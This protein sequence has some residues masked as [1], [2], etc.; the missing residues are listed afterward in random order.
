MAALLSAHPPVPGDDLWLTQT[1]E[2]AETVD[3]TRVATL[4]LRMRA[5]LSWWC[6]PGDA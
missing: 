5:R 2:H 4:G 6:R 3:A 1:D